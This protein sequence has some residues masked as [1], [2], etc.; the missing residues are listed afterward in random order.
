MRVLSGVVVVV[1][2]RTAELVSLPI[3]LSDLSYLDL[4]LA[5]SM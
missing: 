5:T 4:S 3:T 1:M 2:L